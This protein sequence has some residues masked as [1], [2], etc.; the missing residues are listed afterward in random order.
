MGD[1]AKLIANKWNSLTPA[2]KQPFEATAGIEKEAY[3]KWLAK[4]GQFLPSSVL[5]KRGSGGPD[6]IVDLVIPVSKVRKIGK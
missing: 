1:V 4:Y 2:E 5:G 6:N 3:S